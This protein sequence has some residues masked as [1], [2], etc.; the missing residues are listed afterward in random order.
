MTTLNQT[1]EKFIAGRKRTFYF[2]IPDE[3]PAQ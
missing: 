3:A 2:R 1:K